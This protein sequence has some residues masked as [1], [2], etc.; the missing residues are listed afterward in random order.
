MNQTH[1]L[2]Q[3][4]VENARTG[5]DACD[6]LLSRTDDIEIR[7]ELMLQRQ[8][9]QEAARDAETRLYNEGVEPQPKGPMARAGMWMGMQIN[10]MMDRSPSHIAD[11]V[12]QGSTM[13]VVEMTK[14]RNSYPDADAHAQ[15]I[16]ANFITQQQEAI[17]RLKTFLR[18]STVV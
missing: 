12:I 10:T 14:A 3:A 13:G 17:D 18:T 1:Q 11:I 6:Q 7:R 15:G 4:I 16:A 2:L 5:A 9:Y 8:Q